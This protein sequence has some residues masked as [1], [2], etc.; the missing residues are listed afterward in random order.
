M[1]APEPEPEPGEEER[2]S[3]PLAGGC[4]VVGLASGAVAA[5]FAVSQD[6]GIVLVWA[7]GFVGLYC[8]ARRPVSDSS[9]TPPPEGGAPDSDDAA[10][11]EATDA[12]GGDAREGMSI[13]PDPERPGRWIVNPH[14]AEESQ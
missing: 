10:G 1:T 9:T 2:A 14:Y 11:H 8:V 6:A 3:R 7:A 4:V 12:E 5:V 13:I